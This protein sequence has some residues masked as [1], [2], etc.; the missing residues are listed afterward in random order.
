[1][2]TTHNKNL[3]WGDDIM[4]N[5]T[6]PIKEGIAEWH[7]AKTVTGQSV[8]ASTLTSLQVETTSWLRSLTDEGIPIGAYG[9]PTNIRPGQWDVEGWTQFLS[10]KDFILKVEELSFDTT[11]IWGWISHGSFP[12]NFNNPSILP[13]LNLQE[14][15]S[16]DPFFNSSYFIP[17]ISGIFRGVNVHDIAETAYSAEEDGDCFAAGLSVYYGV[18]NN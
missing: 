9:N 13:G 16:C 14:N 6:Q 10:P 17:E 11:R 4:S 1:M 18:K 5:I 7:K 15:F 2:T 8:I 3:A 12:G